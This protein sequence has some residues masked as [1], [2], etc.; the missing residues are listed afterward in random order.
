[1]LDSVFIF[2][3]EGVKLIYT[4][5]NGWSFSRKELDK[6]DD[7]ISRTKFGAQ[8]RLISNQLFFLSSYSGDVDGFIGIHTVIYELQYPTSNELV[9][10][11]ANTRMPTKYSWICKDS[12][13]QKCRYFQGKSPRLTAFWKYTYNQDSLLTELTKYGGDRV[14]EYIC[15]SAYT[16]FCKV[17]QMQTTAVGV[18]Q[19]IPQW[20]HGLRNGFPVKSR[21]E[22]HVNFR[23]P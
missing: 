22:I 8:D 2:K 16:D 5:I 19:S 3:P 4:F 7:L 12:V 10:N 1:M 9:I 13:L 23:L 18:M 20:S 14:P 6:G 21:Q 11:Y 15:S 17:C